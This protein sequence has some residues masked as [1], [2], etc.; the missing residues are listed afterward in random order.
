MENAPEGA[1]FHEGWTA[2]LAAQRQWRW[3]PP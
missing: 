2:G 3:Y 1:F